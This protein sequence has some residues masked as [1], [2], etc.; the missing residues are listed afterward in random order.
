MIQLTRA[1]H[2][3][4]ARRTSNADVDGSPLRRWKDPTALPILRLGVHGPRNFDGDSVG[5][6]LMHQS[7]VSASRLQ[8][9]CRAHY[10]DGADRGGD[11]HGSDLLDEE[12]ST[13]PLSARFRRIEQFYASAV[14]WFSRPSCEAR[15]L[16]D[17]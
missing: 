7:S 8:H 1:Q 11:R 3:A 17:A 2:E 16:N 13:G 14:I 10:A 12:I 4:K 5:P 6:T 9:L 15:G